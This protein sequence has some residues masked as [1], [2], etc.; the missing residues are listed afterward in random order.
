[1]KQNPQKI[2][3]TG[4]VGFIGYSLCIK[5]LDRGDFIFG[6]DNHNSYYDPRLKDHRLKSLLKYPNYKHYRYDLC[7]NDKIQNIFATEKPEK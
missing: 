2:I 7:E 6:I 4:S 1:M 5:L 3:I